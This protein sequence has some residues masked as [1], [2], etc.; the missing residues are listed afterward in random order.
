MFTALEAVTGRGEIGSFKTKH[1]RS[2]W[3][4]HN[5]RAKV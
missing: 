3:R 5:S 2:N 1:D 4:K